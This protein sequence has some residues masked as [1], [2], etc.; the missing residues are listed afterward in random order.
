MDDRPAGRSRLGDRRL[1]WPA[2]VLLALAARLPRL[3]ES[4]WFDEVYY[5]THQRFRTF[6]R[7][8]DSVV[9]WIA[10]PLYSLLLWGWAALLGEHEVVVR[11]PS[12]AFGIGSILLLHAL[13]ARLAGPGVA[14]AASAW[15]ALAPAHVWYSQEGTPYALLLLL[16][17]ATA[18]LAAELLSAEVP[19]P[20]RVAGYGAALAGTLLTHYY[21]TALLAP[22]SLVAWRARPRTRRAMLLVHAALG[23]AVAAL[24]LAKRAGG[25]LHTGQWFL[26]A[27][28]G[29]EAW[30]LHF[31]WFLEGN[32]LWTVHPGRANLSW[33]AGRPLLV[34]LQLVAAV[35]VARGVRRALGA[36]PA[37]ALVPGLAA[38]LPV[39]LA[40]VAAL[41]FDHTYIERYAIIGMPFFALL[42]FWGA[43]GDRAGRLGGAAMLGLALAAWSGW[44]VRGGEW[45][46][47][48]PNPD[49]RAA[50]RH[51]VA[52]A[53]APAILVVP[54]RISDDVAF[55]LR[56][57]ARE[58]GVARPRIVQPPKLDPAEAARRGARVAFVVQDLFWRGDPEP[59]L[60]RFAAHPRWRPGASE[61]FF[62]VELLRFDWTDRRER[63]SRDRGPSRR[64]APARPRSPAR[65]TRAP[66]PR[67]RPRGRRAA[68]AP[69][70]PRT[71]AAAG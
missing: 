64:S 34:L 40:A 26:R 61:R 32:S 41:G 67:A 44:L 43:A 60:A 38:G 4:L 59:V 46:V 6:G 54:L 58:R 37:G 69:C 53:P 39:A 47:Y 27:L 51:V 68:A 19:R 66:S 12:L 15:L 5:S 25:K 23:A 16:A 49:L 30:M 1:V 2:L 71:A 11:L 28:D 21:A 36:G 3:G 55:Y 33:L 17:T 18:L 7:L 65:G 13:A 14:L 57:A 52:A 10:A 8:L 50:A 45:T 56:R 42:L 31:H 70:R 22:L 24:L 35:L 63:L 9:E 62:G 48:K 20:R 29:F